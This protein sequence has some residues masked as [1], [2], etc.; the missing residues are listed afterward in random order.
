MIGELDLDQHDI[1]E[2]RAVT[3]KFLGHRP[4]FE[5]A[6]CFVIGGSVLPLG[7]Y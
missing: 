3:I 6:S 1:V 5:G 2:E 4:I 7:V